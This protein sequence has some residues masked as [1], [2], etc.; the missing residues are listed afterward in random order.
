MTTT[1]TPTVAPRLCETSL[2]ATAAT[3]SIARQLS[4]EFSGVDLATA[5]ALLQRAYEL[6]TDAP[7]QDFRILLAERAARR[8]L[9][10][11]KAEQ[12]RS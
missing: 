10:S 1:Q 11:R 12:S 3:D 5:K 4:L 7:I 9:R 8:E 6:T 2:A